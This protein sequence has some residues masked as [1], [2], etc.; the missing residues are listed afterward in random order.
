MSAV[1]E[2]SACG[3]GCGAARGFAGDSALDSGRPPPTR[4]P[5]VP[6]QRHRHRAPSATRVH[7]AS[8][9]A[10]FWHP[11]SL[12]QI[13]VERETGYNFLSEVPDNVENGCIVQLNGVRVSGGSAKYLNDSSTT[14][15]IAC[16][17]LLPW[18]RNVTSK[19]VPSFGP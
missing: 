15:T 3:G 10:A 13:E 16:A 12:H 4:R 14:P 17:P 19:S 7:Q 9:A 18:P 5:Q 1:P 2:S 11:V 8:Q 6:P